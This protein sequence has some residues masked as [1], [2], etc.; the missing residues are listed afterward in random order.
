MA[1]LFRLTAVFSAAVLLIPALS[2]NSKFCRSGSETPVIHEYKD[3][4]SNYSEPLN[5]QSGSENSEFDIRSF[6]VLRT[7]DGEVYD[8]PVRDYVIGAV[9][10]EM[11]ALFSTEALKAQ[12]VAAHTYAVR[13]ALYERNNHTDDLC[14]ADF[15]DDSSRFQAFFSEDEIRERYGENFDEYYGKVAEAADSVI[16]EILVYRDEPIIAAFHSMSSGITESALNVWGTQTDYLVPAESPDDTE[17]PGFEEEYSFTADEIRSRL[18]T[19]YSGIQLDSDCSKWFEIT[20]V[21]S[22]GTV[23]KMN[24]GDKEIT[25]YD[26]RQLL[27]LRSASF[28]IDYSADKGFSITTRGYGHGVGMSQYGANSMAESGKDYREILLH[29][30]SGTEIISVK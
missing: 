22:S 28:T 18:Q 27:S 9:C 6:S 1:Y 17:A 12:A 25:G 20:S 3:I 7:S 15:S 26:L 8:I 23:L 13:Q 2:L 29:Y 16:D 21:S 24:A 19:N 4:K 5:I 14:G 30:Y 11:P 10:A